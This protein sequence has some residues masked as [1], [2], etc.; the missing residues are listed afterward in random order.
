MFSQ[1]SM[2]FDDVQVGMGSFQHVPLVQFPL[3]DAE[4]EKIYGLIFLFKLPGQ[5]D[6]D[7]QSSCR[8]SE[9]IH[10]SL[11]SCHGSALIIHLSFI[12]PYGT[13]D[14]SRKLLR[15][16]ISTDSQHVVSSQ[17]FIHF[18]TTFTYIIIC[19]VFFHLFSS[20]LRWQREA[21]PRP[22]LEASEL[23][24]FFAQQAR[25]LG[26]TLVEPCRGRR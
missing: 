14:L 19:V 22:T 25:N 2:M 21:D 1:C 24:I 23:G 9:M 13:W 16:N 10:C 3:K 18:S 8:F 4:A 7:E 15:R 12:D 26:G 11:C 17:C 5:D 6:S 20:A